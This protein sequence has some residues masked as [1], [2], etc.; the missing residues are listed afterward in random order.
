VVGYPVSPPVQGSDGNFYGVTPYTG[1]YK[2]GVLYRI[3]PG[4]GPEAFKVLCISGALPTNPLTTDKELID[5][6]MFNGSKGNHPVS[7]IAASDGNLYGVAYGGLA[8]NP[9][10]TIFKAT[11]D[12]RVSL[13]HKFD[14]ANGA[15]PYL[16]M[17]GKDGKLY[18]TTAGGGPT[19]GVIYRLPLGEPPPPPTFLK[20]LNGS[21][22][23]M[24]PISGMAQGLDGTLYGTARYGGTKG[25]GVVYKISP[26]GTEFKV[27]HN[28]DLY[29]TGRT[30]LATPVLHS[31]NKL[32][33]TTYQGG[34]HD[35]GVFYSLDL[36]P[37]C[38]ETKTKA[39]S[40]SD[41]GWRMCC[42]FGYH[43]A[44]E[45]ASTGGHHYQTHGDPVGY[46]YTSMGLV[47]L[48]HVRDNADMMRFVYQALLDGYNR[49]ELPEGTATIKDPCDR[50]SMLEL[51]RSITY[52]ESWAHE[53]KT[54]GGEQ[55]FSSFSP[56]DLPSNIVGIELGTRAIKAGGNFDAAVDLELAK[57]LNELKA[58]PKA[59]TAAVLKS[60]EGRWY[61]WLPQIPKLLRRNF[62][63]L[64]WLQEQVVAAPPTL[65][66]P[67]CVR[68]I[69]QTIQ[70]HHQR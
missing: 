61:Q 47:D 5:T 52:V 38:T 56:E 1:N 36:G 63:G 57:L 29:G 48:G 14:L 67:R 32:F 44:L 37:P 45:P 49:L 55:D 26:A 54:W 60:L 23:G 22:D 59:T 3:K 12:G 27:L 8:N 2:F 21:T 25:R 10:G 66:E 40:D 11:L 6:C 16:L 18:G 35:A 62:D 41:P 15:S 13:M 51:A 64:P 65:V 20:K 68:G 42:A 4:G 50:E 9:Y 34:S 33:G 30:P 7:L 39:A 43:S 19:Y 46:V 53:L 31:T 24:S 58:Q 17:Q 28:F 69:L 70:L